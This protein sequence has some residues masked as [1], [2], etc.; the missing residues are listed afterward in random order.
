MYYTIFTC[1]QTLDLM[2][3]YGQAYGVLVPIEHQRH[4]NIRKQQILESHRAAIPGFA[5]VPM[6]HSKELRRKAL[7]SFNLRQLFHPSGNPL[8]I[9]ERELEQLQDRLEREYSGAY[10]FKVGDKVLVH[11]HPLNPSGVEGEVVKFR[12]S[13]NARVKIRKLNTFVEVPQI[14]LSKIVAN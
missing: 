11:F 3:S 4:F 7:S 10:T 2:R 8:V 5:F 13:G 1:K 9:L 14:M 6:E 12:K